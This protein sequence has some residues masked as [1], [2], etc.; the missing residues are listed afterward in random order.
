MRVFRTGL[1]D[2]TT[3]NS[4]T[5]LIEILLNLITLYVLHL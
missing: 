3:G 1:R 2:R 4:N 5:K